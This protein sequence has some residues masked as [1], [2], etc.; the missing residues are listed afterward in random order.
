M[1]VPEYKVNV[2]AEPIDGLS[3]DKYDFECQFYIYSNR[4]VT[5]KKENMKQNEVNG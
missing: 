5:I 3:M 1:F 2:H 4:V